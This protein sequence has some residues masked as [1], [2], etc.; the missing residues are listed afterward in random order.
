MNKTIG[1]LAHVDAG[2]TTWSEQVLYHTKSI[3][4]RGRVDHKDAFLDSNAIEKER[5]ITIFSDEGVFHYNDSNYY[6]ID[7][8]GHADFSS[9]MER[10]IE[11]LDYAI[12]L[13]SAVEGVEAHTETIFEL[14]KKYNVPTFFF[15]NK[16]DRTSANVESAVE[17]IKNNLTKDVCFIKDSFKE[18]EM[19]EDIIEFVAEHDEEILEEYLDKG[20]EKELWIN[21]I[22]KLIKQS[23]IYPCLS[24]SAL[25]DIGIDNFL[26]VFDMLTYTEYSSEG[27]FSG[28]VY[29]IRHDDNK[30]RVTFIKA[31]SGRLKVKD[32]IKIQSSND[33]NYEKVNQIR[34]YN[35]NKFKTQNEVEAGEVF[36]VTGITKLKVGDGIG[37]VK[38]KSHY[39][40]VPTL[41]SKVIF[42]KDLNPQDVLNYFK[43]LEAEDPALN[44]IWDERLKE[45]QV[46]IMG[47]IQIE[48]LTKVVK[49]RFNLEVEFGPCEILYKETI[50]EETEGFGHF[51]PLRHYAE[52]NLKIE[53]AKRNS[54]ITFENKCHNDYLSVGNQNLV[55]THIFEREHRGILTGSPIT[56]IK[57][58][59][60]T[61]RYHNKHTSGGDFREATYRALRQGLEKVKNVLLEPFYRFKIEVDLNSM[62]RVLSDIQKLNGTFK[63]PETIGDKV[64]IKGRGP[65]KTFMNYSMEFVSFTKGKGKINFIFDGYDICHNEKEVIEEM[66]YDKNADIEYTSTS[67]FCSKGQAFLVKWNEAEEYMHCLKK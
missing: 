12:L 37:N 13:I 32:E 48:V 43:I 55:R 52:V 59:L 42:D 18:K 28:R 62:G 63:S 24:G 66:A 1:I 10:S 21:S 15:I 8:P 44:I 61:G 9:E 27:E 38:G 50:L 45:I 41:K 64:V 36:A 30:N 20:Y 60:L 4:N 2:K 22:K 23:K 17:D 19:D 33:E 46:H 34:V 40:M 14:L 39:D 56:D 11:V 26:E 51:E 29:K 49:E 35:G 67:I 54:G 65:V 6:L 47:V 25:Q 57:V 5:G 31:L 58:T 53:P 3:K 7:T 16:I